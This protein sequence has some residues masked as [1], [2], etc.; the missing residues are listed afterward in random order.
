MEKGEDGGMGGWDGVR[1]W[2]GGRRGWDGSK[3]LGWRDE[4]RTG[5]AGAGSPSCPF[6][7]HQGMHPSFQQ[8]LLLDPEHPCSLH[9]IQLL[10]ASTHRLKILKQR[11]NVD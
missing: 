8:F 5:A 10:R 7:A 9:A 3:K 11:I 6:P 2:D 1:G 4:V